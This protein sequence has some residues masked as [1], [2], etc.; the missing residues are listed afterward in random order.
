M[1]KFLFF[2]F[3]FLQISI[4]NFYLPTTDHSTRLALVNCIEWNFAKNFSE[5]LSLHFQLGDAQWHT[6]NQYKCTFCYVEIA[7]QFWGMRLKKMLSWQFFFRFWGS[8]TSPF[9]S[10]STL[11]KSTEIT[12]TKHDDMHPQYYIF[13]LTEF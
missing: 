7:S 1:I 12:I 11:E 10:I 8:S 13:F 4:T 9:T 5:K 6:Q 3:Y 2:I